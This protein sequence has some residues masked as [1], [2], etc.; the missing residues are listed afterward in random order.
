M[1]NEEEALLIDDA[2]IQDS[3]DIVRT[4]EEALAANDPYNNPDYDPEYTVSWD[5]CE[6]PDHI[7][8]P[9]LLLRIVL[10]NEQTNALDY[11]GDLES[12]AEAL[13]DACVRLHAQEHRPQGEE[14]GH[15][16]EVQGEEESVC[17]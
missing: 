8:D 16:S 4:I 6:L 5:D 12:I 13:R 1:Q 2:L 7:E 14:S 3:Y 10:G 11:I 9:L 17:A 15:S